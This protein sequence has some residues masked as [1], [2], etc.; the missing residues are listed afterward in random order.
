MDLGHDQFRIVDSAHHLALGPAT[1]TKK[2]S[3]P[4]LVND[5]I[6]PDTN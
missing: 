1:K 2:A 4:I 3:A 6:T 5:N